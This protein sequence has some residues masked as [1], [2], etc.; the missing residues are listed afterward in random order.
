MRVEAALFPTHMPYDSSHYR[1]HILDRIKNHGDLIASERLT[2]RL[3]Q[4]MIK[5]LNRTARLR[6][7]Y[8]KAKKI[9]QVQTAAIV[10]E[11]VEKTSHKK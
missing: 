7:H 4:Q 6:S 9:N 10:A 2:E 5:L 3:N 11:K 8:Q 1:V